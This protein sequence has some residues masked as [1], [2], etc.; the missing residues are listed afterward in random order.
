MHA[1]LKLANFMFVS[2]RAELIELNT[3]LATRYIND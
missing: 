3:N 2:A 1:L